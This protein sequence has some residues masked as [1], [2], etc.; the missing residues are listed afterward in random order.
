MNKY[1]FCLFLLLTSVCFAATTS[2]STQTKHPVKKKT[3]VHSKTTAKKKAVVHPAAK[4]AP[5]VSQALYDE[6]LNTIENDFAL[7]HFYAQLKKLASGEVKQVSIV[8]IGDSHVQADFFTGTLRD[9]F[10]AHFGNAGRGLYFPY[11]TAGTNGPDG[12]KDKGSEASWKMKRCAFPMQ[13]M[14]IGLMGITL[15]VAQNA[16]IDIYIRAEDSA[17]YFNEL[18]VF[19]DNNGGESITASTIDGAVLF[20]AEGAPFHNKSQLTEFELG[21]PLSAIKLGLHPS[22]IDDT[23]TQMHLYGLQLNRTD[24]VGVQYNMIGVNGAKFSD[25]NASRYFFSQISKVPADLFVISL[26]TNEALSLTYAADSMY[27]ALDQFY[28]RLRQ[29]QPEAS[30][31]FTAPPDTY[32]QH[33]NPNP[34]TAEIVDIERRYSIAH[35]CAFWDFYMIM[36]GLGSVTNWYKQGL[37]NKDLVH[38][39]RA[40]YQKQGQ[41]LY[42]ALMKAYL[43]S[44]NV[45]K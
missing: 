6:Q 31:L 11:R 42:R 17:N 16:S 12:I 20:A 33:L 15:E 43:E 40:G 24:A 35:D 27:M 25:Y 13:P 1:I 18:R 4:T 19:A 14:P 10:Q 23:T 9:S 3:A 44:L 5:V 26:G 37:G 22:S 38:F 39:L 29:V 34:H 32:Y 41:L 45:K 8:H 30:I 7:R 28:T 21:K 36:G 2:A